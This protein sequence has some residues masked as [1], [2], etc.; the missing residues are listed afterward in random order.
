MKRW[1]NQ[2]WGALK[3]SKPGRRFQDR[4]DRQNRKG[5]R[6]PWKRTLNLVLAVLSL[7]IGFVLVFIPGPA[8]LFFLM[9]GSLL[10][11]ESRAIAEALDRLELFLRAS[12]VKGRRFW[13]RRSTW[14]KATLLGTAGLCVAA[15]LLLSYRIL[16]VR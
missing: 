16:V 3:R 14:A 5:G 15:T 11:T 7:A 4:Y 12:W 6:S 13:K 1:L 8:V 9:S 2:H 10:A